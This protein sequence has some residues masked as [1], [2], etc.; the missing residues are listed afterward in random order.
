MERKIIVCFSAVNT[1]ANWRN[2]KDGETCPARVSMINRS[3][4]CEKKGFVRC[5]MWWSPG[6]HCICIEAYHVTPRKWWCAFSSR[7]Q[8]GIL[9]SFLQTKVT[10]LSVYLSACAWRLCLWLCCVEWRKVSPPNDRNSLSIKER[11]LT[12]PF[13]VALARKS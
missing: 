5:D 4:F 1:S 8:K 10:S 6:Q 7:A 2:W 11:S 12:S 3:L 9:L 13:S